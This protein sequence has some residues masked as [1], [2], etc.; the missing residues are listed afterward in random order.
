MEASVLYVRPFF[1]S[2]RWIDDLWQLRQC[3]VYSF[4]TVCDHNRGREP[5]APFNICM[6]CTYMS[7]LPINARAIYDY[8]KLI[9]FALHGLLSYKLDCTVLQLCSM[10]LSFGTRNSPGGRLQASLLPHR[11]VRH[12]PFHKTA[13]TSVRVSILYHTVLSQD[14]NLYIDH[15]QPRHGFLE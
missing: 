4:I 6:Y 2:R 15:G 7:L 8:N 10:L 9:F 13:V 11:Q 14:S 12:T 5:M 3:A 1:S